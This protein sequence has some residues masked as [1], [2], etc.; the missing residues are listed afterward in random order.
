MLGRNALAIAVSVLAL[1]FVGFLLKEEELG[2]TDRQ[3]LVGAWN[4]IDEQTILSDGTVI[5]N[6]GHSAPIGILV[7]DSSGHV[8]SQLLR[9]KILPGADG[10]F[11][12]EGYFGTYAVDTGKET[13]TCHVDGALPNDNIGKEIAEQFSIVGNKLTTR[14][15]T[16]R[17][18][19]L[20]ATRVFMWNRLN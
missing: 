13:I 16:S 2:K 11:E 14:S 18:G 5:P 1:C 9:Q 12:Y 17:P 10:N 6:R 7:Y 4:L 8:A 3:R 15:S 19:A 20:P